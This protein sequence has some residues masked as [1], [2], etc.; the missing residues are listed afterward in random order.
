MTKRIAPSY[1]RQLPD[2][3]S[4]LI[5]VKGFRGRFKAMIARDMQCV[6][7]L[8]DVGGLETWAE[9]PYAHVSYFMKKVKR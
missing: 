6:I 8:S 1:L 4:I 7:A 2:M 5:K 3:A 9:I